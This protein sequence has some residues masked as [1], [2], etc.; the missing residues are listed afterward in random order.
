MPKFGRIGVGARTFSP[1]K[2][3][4]GAISKAKTA[5]REAKPAEF[6][7]AKPLSTAEKSQR[8]AEG[9]M[10]ETVKAASLNSKMGS[11]KTTE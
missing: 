7:K 8:Q 1:P 11:R 3:D 5:S 9:K 4:S 6:K 10:N 2:V